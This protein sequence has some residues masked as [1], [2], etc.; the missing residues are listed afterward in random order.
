MP[1][2]WTNIDKGTI[3]WYRCENCGNRHHH[4]NLE[5]VAL[6]FPPPAVTN[7]SLTTNARSIFACEEMIEKKVGDLTKK[8][9]ALLHKHDAETPLIRKA[10]GERVATEPCDS[11]YTRAS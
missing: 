8:V 2:N 6:M 10:L 7:V 11:P 5:G 3:G 1:H 4:T 9:A